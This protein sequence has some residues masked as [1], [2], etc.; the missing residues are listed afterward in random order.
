[1]PR[2]MDGEQSAGRLTSAALRR[3]APNVAAI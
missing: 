3:C 2:F 1:M